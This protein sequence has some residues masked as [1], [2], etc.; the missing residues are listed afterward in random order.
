VSLPININSTDRGDEGE[1]SIPFPL[2]GEGQDE[3]AINPISTLTPSYAEASDLPGTRLVVG[4]R[5]TKVLLSPGKKREI[6]IQID[7]R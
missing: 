6:N 1:I 5:L 3:G 2:R 7:K 4:S